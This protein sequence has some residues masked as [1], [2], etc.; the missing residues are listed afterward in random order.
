MPQHAVGFAFHL[1][2][3]DHLHDRLVAVTRAGPNTY[4][5]VCW[6]FAAKNIVLGD[7]ADDDDDDDDDDDE[8]EEEEDLTGTC[9]K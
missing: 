8:E 1:D 6:S 7:D 5:A 4:M 3:T 2:Q 9:L